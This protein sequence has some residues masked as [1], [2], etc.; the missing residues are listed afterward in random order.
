MREGASSV[1][2]GCTLPLVVVRQHH[3]GGLVVRGRSNHLR[4]GTRW[5]AERAA[6]QL[7]HAQQAVLRIEKQHGKHPMPLGGQV[8]LVSSA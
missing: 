4:A 1:R 2:L 7:F 6:K 5:S 8:K 3:T